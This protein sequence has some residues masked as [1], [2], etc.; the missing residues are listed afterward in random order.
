M[1]I[2][3]QSFICS[4]MIHLIYFIGTLGV[5]FIRT[6]LYKPDLSKTFG[7]VETLQNEVAFGRGI[8]PFYYLLSF[9]GVMVI[10][11]MILFFYKKRIS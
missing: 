9:V 3:I 1:K 7:K 10:C 4:C 6:R 11:G 5:G 2:I 8:S